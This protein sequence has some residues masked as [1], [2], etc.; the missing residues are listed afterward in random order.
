M[1]KCIL[2]VAK[3]TNQG[4][5]TGKTNHNYRLVEVPNADPQRKHLN[6]E[7]VN[8]GEKNVWELTTERIGQVGIKG[9][10]KD[11]VHGM[12][13]LITASPD[14]FGRDNAGLVLSDYRSSAWVS[15]NLNFLRQKYGANLVAFTLHQDEKTPHIH[16]IVVPIT[17][18]GR[19]S[20]KELFNPKSLRSLQTE[21]AQAMQPHGLERG[22]EG[23]RARHQDMKQIYGL[24]EQT[25]QALESDLK[26]LQVP[27]LSLT[28]DK[29]GA[30]DLLNLERWRTQQEAKINAEHK[31]QLEESRKVAQKAQNIAVAN[32]TALE[33]GK[34]LQQRLNTSEGLK[35]AHYQR[36]EQLSQ[37]I[38]S[39]NSHLGWLLVAIDEGRMGKQWVHEQAQQVRDRVVPQ[40]KKDMVASLEKLTDNTDVLHRLTKK[41]YEVSDAKGE[42]MY[43]VEP[44]TGVRL[45]LISTQIEGKSFGELVLDAVKKDQQ[46]AKQP[47]HSRSQDREQDNG[48]SL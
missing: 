34:V 3:I 14:V 16:A 22:I 23:S 15:D 26:P 21:Y 32:A 7:Y 31:H 33:Q 41:G 27:N 28:I 8:E 18:D 4:S 11:A 36:V 43:L 40:M 17:A 35:Q 1:S 39:T 6:Q 47:K 10:R 24:Q 48:Q 46:P 37:T 29:P 45:S 2:R 42:E 13:F 25:R 20:A 30:L 19:L 12:E 5:A 44:K 9:V 38:E